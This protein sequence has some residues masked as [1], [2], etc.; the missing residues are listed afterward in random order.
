MK[1][2]AAMETLL[3]NHSGDPNHHSP[4]STSQLE[5]S[6]LIVSTPETLK[7]RWAVVPKQTC[8]HQMQQA[9][10]RG[11]VTCFLTPSRNLIMNFNLL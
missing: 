11:T 9:Q 1:A 3:V 8:Y 10:K 4:F 5:S 6:I 2:M 7:S